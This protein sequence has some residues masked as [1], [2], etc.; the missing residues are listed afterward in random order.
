[1]RRQEGETGTVV[2][3]EAALIER[4]RGRGTTIVLCNPCSTSTGGSR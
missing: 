3:T 4:A 1:M 2:A